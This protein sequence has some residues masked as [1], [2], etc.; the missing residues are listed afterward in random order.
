MGLIDL[1]KGG[2]PADSWVLDTLGSSRGIER[3]DV[4]DHAARRRQS[5]PQ[6][7]RGRSDRRHGDQ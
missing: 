5:R 4:A 1:T 2:T 6:G 7:A 3:D